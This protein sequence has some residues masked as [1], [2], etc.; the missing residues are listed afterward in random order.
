M[1][2]NSRLHLLIYLA[3][4]FTNCSSVYGRL[5]SGEMLYMM[6]MFAQLNGLLISVQ[7]LVESDPVT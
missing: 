3:L 7:K 5:I 4:M 6:S 2:K 1:D